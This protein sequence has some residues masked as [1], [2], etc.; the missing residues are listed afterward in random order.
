MSNFLIRFFIKSEEKNRK[1]IG[2]LS[3]VTGVVCNLVLFLIK[4]FVGISVN[5]VAVIADSFNNLSDVGTSAVSYIGFWLSDKPADKEHP[6]G[7][8]RTEYISAL[9]V[10]IVII[11]VGYELF[12]TSIDRIVNPELVIFKTYVIYILIATIV[13]KLWLSNF[14]N[15]LD[16][17]INSQALKAASLDSIADVLATSTVLVSLIISRYTEL[18]VDGIVGII[19]A[20]FIFVNGIRTFKSTITMLI[21]GNHDQHLIEE[22]EKYITHFDG[23]KGVHDTIVHDYGPDIKLAT[24]HVEISAS[25][26]SI[27]AHNIIDEIEKKVFKKFGISLLI[28]FDPVLDK[29]FISN[30]NKEKVEKMLKKYKQVL[31]MHDFRIINGAKTKAMVF[32]I[33][34]DEKLTL[35]NMGKLK[36]ELIENLKEYFEDYE[37]I[38]TLEKE[39]I[40]IHN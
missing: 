26:S 11:F 4:L 8:G 1:K 19:V 24:S 6:F 18:P 31:S 13:I 40:Y 35:D 9:I 7:H 28:H 10:S 22:I 3:S 12:K 39:H 25:Y 38:I 27:V 23:I 5:S 17:L 20:I 16:K 36:L 33:I 32:D 34:V 14:N 37:F 30:E 29:C 21:G 15:K 2:Y